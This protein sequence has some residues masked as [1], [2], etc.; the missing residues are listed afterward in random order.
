[1]VLPFWYWLTKVVLE[2]RPLNGCSSGS[3]KDFKMELA[4]FHCQEITKLDVGHDVMKTDI[5]EF[6]E[7]HM[8]S[9]DGHF[10]V[11]VSWPISAVN[12]SPYLFQGRTR[13]INKWCIVFLQARCLSCHSTHDDS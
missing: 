7:K 3:S 6:R 1:M 13:V 9:F 12:F 10:P 8:C 11:S 2:K 4:V 5:A